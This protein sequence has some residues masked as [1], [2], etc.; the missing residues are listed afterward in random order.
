MHKKISQNIIMFF[1]LIWK[2][3]VIGDYQNKLR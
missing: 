2:F 1:F 3:E